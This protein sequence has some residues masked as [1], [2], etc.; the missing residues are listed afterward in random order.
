MLDWQESREVGLDAL[1][2]LDARRLLG[3]E[4]LT[5]VCLL[6]V[7]LVLAAYLG[8]CQVSLHPH[9]QRKK[10]T[11]FQEQL[12]GRYGKVPR[13]TL[14]YVH[15]LSLPLFAA[16][17]PS[18]AA[19]SA[20]FSA[21]APVPVPGT[22]LAIP[23]L[24]LVL[25]LSDVVQSVPSFLP[26]SNPSA[27]CHLRYLCIRAVYGLTAEY[28]ALT[29]TL[30]VTLRKFISLLLS[31]FYFGSPFTSLHWLGTGLVFGGT[32][33]FSDLPGLIKARKAKTE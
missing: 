22:D 7:A 28:S 8:I 27:G 15:A 26:S 29:V 24:W 13:E 16:L 23:R 4:I 18:I 32:A 11:G 1:G 17:G 6:F 33:V 10:G 25:L 19:H 5:G 20:H 12:Y 3:T 2:G 31:I 21:S 14:F 9:L 30:V